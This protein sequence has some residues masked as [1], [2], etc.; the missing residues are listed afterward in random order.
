MAKT[1]IELDRNCGCGPVEGLTTSGDYAICMR[2]LCKVRDASRGSCHQS[3]QSVG[4]VGCRK[5]ESNLLEPKIMT[6]AGR[7]R[8]IFWSQN[9]DGA[10][11]GPTTIEMK[12]KQSSMTEVKES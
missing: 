10:S 8:V 5:D 1:A 11:A 9:N 7:M 3:P 2:N 6:G 4:S 12:H